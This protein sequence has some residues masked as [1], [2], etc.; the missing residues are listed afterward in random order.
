MFAT[1]T[2]PVEYLTHT[3][4]VVTLGLLVVLWAWE[5]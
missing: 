3:N 1:T 5:T 4:G 2:V